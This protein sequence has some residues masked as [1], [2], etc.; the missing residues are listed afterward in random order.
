MLGVV[1]GSQVHG[2]RGSRYHQRA[3]YRSE[4]VCRVVR[5]MYQVDEIWSYLI[6][7]GSY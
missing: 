5:Y 2:I 6:E 7:I 3:G 1:V 4:Q